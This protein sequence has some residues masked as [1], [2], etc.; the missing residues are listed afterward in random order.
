MQTERDA[1]SVQQREGAVVV[2]ARIAK[3]NGVQT[4]GWQRLEEGL[5]PFEI[6]HPARRQLVKH[7]TQPAAQTA[8]PREQARD[9]GVGILQLLHMSQVTAR[10]DGV[11]ELRW[12]TAAP[13]RKRRS[14][15]QPV[16]G[17]VDLDG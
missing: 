1:V 15:G 10:L 7:R 6:A 14:V 17:V 12:N 3:F 13:S 9:G 4:V 2:P 8:R 5:E 11:D 16:E